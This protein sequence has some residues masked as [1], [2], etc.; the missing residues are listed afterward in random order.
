[1]TKAMSDES[2]AL[3][4]KSECTCL[5]AVLGGL[6]ACA[7]SSGCL[8][9][10]F[11]DVVTQLDSVVRTAIRAEN[12]RQGDSNW[13]HVLA[14]A[15]R[16]ELAAYL[17]HES[18]FPGDTVSLFGIS[19]DSVLAVS[20]Y[21]MGWY[22]GSGARLISNF[23]ATTVPAA[24]GCSAP[25]PGPAECLWPRS[26]T[27]PIPS[28]VL[29]GVYVVR[30]TDSRGAARFIPLVVKARQQ[31]RVVVVLSFNTYQAY[32]SWGG[33]SLYAL[34]D[35]TIF[36]PRVSFLRPYSDHAVLLRFL[37]TDVPLVRFLERWGYPVSYVGDRDFDADDQI[38]FGGRVVI[39]S[40]HSE[41]WSSR[42]RNHAEL[43]RTEGVGLAFFG[44]ND[45]YWQVRYEG[46][47]EGYHGDVLVCYKSNADPLINNRSLATVRFR[48]PAVGRPE[49]ALIGVMHNLN[50]NGSHFVRLRVKSNDSQLLER[51]GFQ[52]GDTTSLIGG[53]EGD[54]TFDNGL[55]RPGLN[56]LFETP[57][58]VQTT[59]VPDVIQTT[60]YRDISGAG[61]FAAG[62]V[63]WNWA[64][65]DLRPEVAD[66]RVQQL[67]RNLL[68]WYLR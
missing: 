46:P 7:M 61:V 52:L 6:A 41:Y 45:S 30:Y 51:T 29:P 32:N 49:N 35:G 43:L 64:L 67:V 66:T 13:N 50:P 34:R 21:R 27:L 17:S 19:Q 12:A 40:G 56:V 58:V 24:L 8:D 53:W 14:P 20:L 65:D 62:T 59:G 63:A 4:M 42:M 28:D 1:M 57:Y 36:A 10:P 15:S 39:F 54:K 26:A 3:Y 48:D 22:G 25:L 37:M 23:G 44:A 2:L 5:S 11:S 55:T 47:G 38:G 68:D 9:L 31:A 60:F 18:V 33:A 16:E